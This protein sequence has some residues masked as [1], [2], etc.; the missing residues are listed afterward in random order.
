[1]KINRLVRFND[2]SGNIENISVEEKK[3]LGT[4]LSVFCRSPTL[5]SKSAN[6]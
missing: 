3:E 6:V 1:M 2:Q 5:F 4:N